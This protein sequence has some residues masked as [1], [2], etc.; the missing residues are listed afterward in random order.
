MPSPSISAHIRTIGEEMLASHPDY[1]ETALDK[2]AGIIP[3]CLIFEENERDAAQRGSVV[4]G[5]NPGFSDPPERAYYVR[6]GCTYQATVDYW[7]AKVKG[8][9]YYSMLASF[10]NAAGL[11]GSVLWTEL[12]HCELRDK[13]ARLGIPTI[14][15]SINRYLFRE[16]EVIPTPW[17]LIAV[18]KDVFPILAYRF[19]ERQVIGIPHPTGSFGQFPKLCTGGRITPQAAQQLSHII[20]SGDP[21]A[22]SFDAAS[23]TFSYRVSPA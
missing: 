10:I 18:G 22:A 20:A 6:R 8:V 17:P 13:A 4:V 9:R 3:R 1:P 23:A 16:L 12:V 15:D 11:T 19:P 14:R 2:S 5:I 7:N 21:L